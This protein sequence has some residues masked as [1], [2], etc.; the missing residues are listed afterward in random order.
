MKL[1]SLPW[2]MVLHCVTGSC[3]WVAPWQE[4]FPEGLAKKVGMT[5]F[6]PNKRQSYHHG[7]LPRALLDAALQLIQEEGVRGFTLREV[8]RRAGVSH[9][10]PYRHFADK[11][12]LLAAVAEEGFRGLHARMQHAC[13]QGTAETRGRLQVLGVEYVRFAVERPAH[14]DVMFSLH[15]AECDAFPDLQEIAQNTFTLLTEA[16]LSGQQAGIIRSGEASLLA[17]AAWSIVH[18][19]ATLLINRQVP[20]EGEAQVMALAEQITRTLYDGLGPPSVA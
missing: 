8:A 12:A 7:D 11:T 20:L 6:V 19:L 10:A 3:Q 14:F 15:I 13:S 9:A 16:I 18:G 1:L 17:I 2:K 5:E 4:R